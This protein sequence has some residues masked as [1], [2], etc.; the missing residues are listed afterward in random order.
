MNLKSKSYYETYIGKTFGSLI[1]KNLIYDTTK[2]GRLR[3]RYLC[4]CTN[5]NSSKEIP[6]FYIL[7]RNQKSCGCFKYKT[8]IDHNS[9]IGKRF[10]NLTILE[11]QNHKLKNDKYIKGYYLCKCDCGNIVLYQTNMLLI[12]NYSS[13]GC[14]QHQEAMKNHLKNIGTKFGKLTII[15]VKYYL[16][17]SISTRYKYECKCDCGNIIEIPTSQF[18]K[19]YKTTC[20]NCFSNSKSYNNYIELLEYCKSEN[21]ELISEYNTKATMVLKD[22]NLVST[23]YNKFEF[24]CLVCNSK[25]IK[26]L[27]PSSSLICPNCYNSYKSNCEKII[28]KFLND[29]NVFFYTDYIKSK[30]DIQSYIELD[31]NIP[32]YNLAIEL[33]GLQTHSTFI[34]D[35]NIIMCKSKDQTYHLNKLETCID[36]NIDLLQFWNIEIIQKLDIVKSIIQN[37]L[38]KTLYKEYARNCFI[39]EIDFQT[40]NNFLQTHHIQGGVNG[41]SIRIGLFHKITNN[42]VA[43]MTFGHSRYSTHSYE[44][45]RF[46]THINCRI[47]G[48]A[49]KLFKYFINEY[50]PNSIISYSDRRLFNS[51]KLYEVLGF[52]LDHISPPNYWYF[53]KYGYEKITKLFHR[54]YFQ[55]SKLSELLPIFDINKTEWENMEQNNYL[56]IYD[57]GSKVYIWQR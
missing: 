15:N 43:V 20:G 28:S 19:F 40:S 25:F 4:D 34:L 26:T 56:R 31:F 32:E 17:N 10:G 33:H 16:N 8:T 37:K 13:C 11:Y 39:K 2:K 51:G 38:N 14:K 52:K 46:A 18:L 44:L 3:Y 55:K 9:N 36:N 6:C 21:L 5:C 41:D 57:C 30:S 1:I 45:F 53:K 23:I 35:P 22:N 29:L 42:L 50:S 48:G 47:T 49:S 12:Q 24:K 7:D 54:S 27:S